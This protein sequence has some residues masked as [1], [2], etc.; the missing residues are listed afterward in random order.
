M[1][2]AQAGEPLSWF[3]AGASEARHVWSETHP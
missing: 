2:V 1:D 3:K